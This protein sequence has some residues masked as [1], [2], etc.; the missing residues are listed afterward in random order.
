VL[1]QVLRARTPRA[2]WSQLLRSDAD[3]GWLRA[4]KSAW[5]PLELDGSEPAVA[6]ALSRAFGMLL[7]RYRATA[8]V[9]KALHLKRPRLVPILDAFVVDQLGGRLPEQAR[10]QAPDA[11]R[12]TLHLHAQTRANAAYL[13]QTAAALAARGIERTPLRLV[14]IALWATHPKNTSLAPLRF[15]AGPR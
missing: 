13:A 2:A 11:T 1:N 10:L 9:T 3:S 8:V 14:D 6:G 12:M 7:G 15:R 5:D 4:L